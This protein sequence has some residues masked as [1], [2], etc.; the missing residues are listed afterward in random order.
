MK[1]ILKMGTVMLLLALASSCKQSEASA[2]AATF[3]ATTSSRGTAPTSDRP[4]KSAANEVALDVKAPKKKLIRT[5]DI[6][7]RV[8]DVAQSTYAIES[9]VTRFGGMV[10]HS[11]LQS[12]VGE[13]SQ[14]KISTDSLLE[15]TKY[16]VENNIT[17]RVPNARL[18]TVIDAI[19]KEI[20]YLDFRVVKADDVALRLLSNEL[21]QQRTDRH[22]KRLESDIDQKG[23]KLI[24]INEAENNILSK[25]TERDQAAIDNLSLEDQ[26]NFST[27]T[28]AL[29]QKE[30]V[31]SEIVAIDK[32]GNNYG[33]FGLEIVDGLKTG[34]HILERI[35]AFIAQLWSVILIGILAT[36]I[37]RKYVNRKKVT[38][39]N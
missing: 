13:R 37:L 14:M 24:D 7:F 35:I 25:Q 31:K 5:A 12:H 39:S 21:A 26:V 6:K 8:K 16:N 38:A 20:D 9:S 29:Y 33:S 1:T 32:S 22:T 30:S 36:Y 27:L 23:K 34:W 19:R 17:I 2:D 15:T 28:L 4:A 18:D 11:N 10:A 3:E